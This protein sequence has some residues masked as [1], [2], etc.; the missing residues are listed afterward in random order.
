MNPV[1]VIVEAGVNQNSDPAL[2]LKIIKVVTNS[3]AD[4]MKVQTLFFKQ[5]GYELGVNGDL[6]RTETA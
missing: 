1:F 3:F 5:A 2:A 4:A 6:S